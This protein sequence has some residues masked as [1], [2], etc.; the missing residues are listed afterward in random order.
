[1]K[2][3]YISPENTAGTLNLWKKAHE[4]LGNY[5]RFV[6]YYPSSI[7]YQDDIVLN[8]P[9]V[10]TSK[11]YINFRRLLQKFFYN[12]DPLIEK[13]DQY[14]QW[15]P[16]NILE[17]YWFDLRDYLWSYKIEPIIN[18]YKLDQFDIIHF[19]WGL[20]LYRDCR[21]AKKMK[22]N[23]KSIIC[24]YHGPDIR[25]RGVI[26]AL[27]RLSNINLDGGRRCRRQKCR[28]TA[29]VGEYCEVHALQKHE[30]MVSNPDLYAYL[31]DSSHCS[32]LQSWFLRR[33]DKINVN[34]MLLWY[35]IDNFKS[36]SS[37][38]LRKSRSK[39]V[40]RTYS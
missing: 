16:V 39:K 9:L 5:C 20:D 31:N 6:T 12:R 8:L 35:A 28:S 13:S 33:D 27:D 36:C 10:G 24:H 22:K 2:I 26:P 25:A 21:F 11:F 29:R 14:P 4:E 32:R 15:K 17:K 18:K 3:L 23:E 40:E 38:E 7:G 19:E 37:P 34:R 30:T 1:M